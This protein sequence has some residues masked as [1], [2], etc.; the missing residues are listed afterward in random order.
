MRTIK[1]EDNDIAGTLTVIFIDDNKEIWRDIFT[2]AAGK[3]LFMSNM[4]TGGESLFMSN[5]ITN[6]IRYG[7]M[8][9]KN[10]SK[11]V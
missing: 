5:M 1:I 11:T 3:S 10:E 4:L 8:P 9:H 2:Y 6:W 7:D